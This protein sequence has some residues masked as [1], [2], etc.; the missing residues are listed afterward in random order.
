MAWI[1]KSYEKPR[2]D[3]TDYLSKHFSEGVACEVGVCRGEFS[4]HLLQNWNCKKLYLVDFW[5]HTES[6]REGFHKQNE[7]YEKMI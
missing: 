2:Q 5:D 4:K 7:N 3:I 6:Y 1:G